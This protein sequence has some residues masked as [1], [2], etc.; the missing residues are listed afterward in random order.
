MQKPKE[1]HLAAAKYTLKYLSDLASKGHYKLVGCIAAP[2]MAKIFRTIAH[3]LTTSF[4]SLV[5]LL[6]G[7]V[8]NKKLQLALLLNL[9]KLS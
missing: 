4:L 2:I 1:M 9:S 8:E 3:S 6:H 7:L 5:R